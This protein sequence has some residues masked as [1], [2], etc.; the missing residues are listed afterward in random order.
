[1]SAKE[2]LGPLG[3]T[4]LAGRRRSDE[5]DAAFLTNDFDAREATLLELMCYP[6]SGRGCD[7]GEAREL[8]QR[9]PFT[10]RT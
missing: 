5:P 1:M 6:M 9:D 8:A 4:R 7:P 3:T 10:T 2:D